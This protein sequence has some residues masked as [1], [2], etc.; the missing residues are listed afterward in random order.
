MLLQEPICEEKTISS[1][2]VK[3]VVSFLVG[4]EQ[5]KS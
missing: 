3:N 5:E 1:T 2:L 4:K